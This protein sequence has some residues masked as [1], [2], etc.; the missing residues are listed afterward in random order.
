L[1]E[2]IQHIAVLIYGSPELM[3]FAIDRQKYL[4]EVPLVA[5]LGTPATELLGLCQRS[6]VG[7]THMPY[8]ADAVQEHG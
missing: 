4:V 3:A 5:W 7:S 2:N 1:Y 8:W 6:R